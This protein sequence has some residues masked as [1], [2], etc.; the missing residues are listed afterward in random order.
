MQAA[1]ELGKYAIGVDSDQAILYKDVDPELAELIPTSVL[2][3]VDISLFQA[4]EA[5]SK[6]ELKWGTRVAVGIPEDGIGLADNEI[7]QK[8]VPEETRK[9]VD[10][11]TKKIKNG[12]VEVVTAF[13]M[14]NDELLKY[15]DDAK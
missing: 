9:L 13:N 6:G 10:D 8:I 3:R 2:K 5:A 11:Y 15:V 12:E 4:I 14:D 1:K 7:Y